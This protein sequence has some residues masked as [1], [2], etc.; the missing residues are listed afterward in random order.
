MYHDGNERLWESDR[1][2]LGGRLSIGTS[3]IA[4]TADPE[5]Y[6]S[7][8]WGSFTYAVPVAQGQYGVTLRFAE[9]NFGIF[10][11]GDSK[12]DIGGIGSRIFDVYCNGIVLIKNLDIFKEAHGPNKALEKSFHGLTP[13]GQGKLFLSFVPVKDYPTVRAIEVIDESQ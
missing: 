7:E 1:Y 10:N 4:G 3:N 9:S 6:S 8:R 12:Y 5:M 2:F 11:F 13:N